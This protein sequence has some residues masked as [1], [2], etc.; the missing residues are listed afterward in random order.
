[1]RAFEFPIDFE[2]IKSNLDVLSYISCIHAEKRRVLVFYQVM[3]RF[4]NV[5]YDMVM[6]F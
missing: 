6:E 4:G 3:R 5:S 1:M 2:A